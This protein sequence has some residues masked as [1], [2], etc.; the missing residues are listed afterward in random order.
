MVVHLV[1]SAPP[2]AGEFPFTKRK[3]LKAFSGLYNN[4][5]HLFEENST[6]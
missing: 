6:S 4:I 1:K 3:S 2:P 5:I